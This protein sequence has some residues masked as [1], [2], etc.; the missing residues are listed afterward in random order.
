MIQNTPTIGI[1][2]GTFL[3][4]AIFFYLLEA[5]FPAIR[6]QKIFR[7]GFLTDIV[8]WFFTPLVTRFVS[9]TS[10]YVAI[11][12]ISFLAVSFLTVDFDIQEV[13]KNGFGPIADQPKV[14]IL[15]ELLLCMDFMSYWVHRAFHTG[16][17]WKFHAIH[18]ASEEVD[19]LS[20]VRLHPVNDLAIRFAQAIPLIL[21]GFPVS[22]VATVAPILTLHAFFLHA[23]VPWD[24]GPLRFIF[25]SPKFHRWHHTSEIEGRDK[26]FAGLFPVFDLIFG[27]IYMPKNSQ[28]KVF[29]IG[30]KNVPRTFWQQMIY[31]FRKS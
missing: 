11:L 1:L 16:R 24:L 5:I 27:T 25:S 15:I 23:N 17:W 4:L 22:I 6:N 31:P 13:L 21:I 8:Y 10:V 14:L 18:H 7:K 2:V 29:G 30:D 9:K 26:N 28:P 20:S 3:V 12:F 19:W